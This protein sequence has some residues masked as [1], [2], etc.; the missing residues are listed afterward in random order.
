ERPGAHASGTRT[1]SGVPASRYETSA[2]TA[3]PGP[4]RTGAASGPAR[5]IENQAG[6]T[7]KTSSGPKTSSNSKPSKRTTVTS[8]WLSPTTRR[9]CRSS[10]L[11]CKR[12]QDS[13]GTDVPAMHPLGSGSPK[14]GPVDRVEVDE[15]GVRRTKAARVEVERREVRLEVDM[16]P[17]APHSSCVK[18]SSADD[19]GPDPHTLA[20]AACPRAAQKRQTA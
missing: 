6:T 12:V 2:T 17:L 9:Q 8:R 4:L 7:P 11:S 18:R 16:E 3:G 14:S 20:A 10:D 19:L 1:M 5:R 13:V 15:S